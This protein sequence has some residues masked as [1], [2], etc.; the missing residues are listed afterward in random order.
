V[1]EVPVGV[2]YNAACSAA[3]GIADAGDEKERARLRKM[4]LDWLAAELALWKDLAAKGGAQKRALEHL[5]F[6]QKDRDLAAVRRP[7]ALAKLPGSEREAWEKLW[8]AARRL[9]DELRKQ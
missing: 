3:L 6:W 5:E 2:R 1:R 4:A 8:A 9:A 7:S